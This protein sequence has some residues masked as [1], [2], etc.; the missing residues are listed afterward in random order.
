MKNI[1]LIFFIL[2]SCKLLATATPTPTSAT[3][4]LAQLLKEVKVGKEAARIVAQKREKVF[5]QKRHRQKSLLL[6][7]KKNLKRL[8]ERTQQLTT[9]FESNEK[10]LATLEEKLTITAGT[11][12][13][14][15]GVVKQVAGDFKGQFENSII[16]TQFK[17]RD[18]LMNDLAQRKKLPTISEIS[19]LWYEMTREMIES[20]KIVAFKDDVV[21][22]SGH[23]AQQEIIRIGSFNLIA[24]G[25]YLSYLG[26]T[27]QIIEL[28]RQPQNKYLAMAAD[29]GVLKAGYS[30]F[31]LDPSR[32]AILSMLVQAPSFQ[33]R[34]EQG[35]V[36][37]YVIL[38]LLFIGLILVAE[39][40]VVLFKE[41]QKI[42][43]QLSSEKP[44][45]D[46]ILGQLMKIFNAYKDR[47]SETLELKLEESIIKATPKL[48][49]GISSIKILSAVA[50]LLGLLGT[51]TGMIATFQSI[52]LF[53]TG[54]PKLMA[55]GI[56]TALITTV[57]GLVCAI[58]LL[59]LHN[60]VYTKSK[61]LMQILEEQSA[62][63]M[64]LKVENE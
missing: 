2:F 54:D 38:T 20:G 34:I 21:S 61:R 35:G 16:S 11:L 7:A 4:R 44:L 51:V 56:S 40:F 37:G 26:S 45:D 39:R 13:E 19:R 12:G 22:P 33:E 41:D 15:F 32:G 50:P 49:R 36:V 42:Q 23:K 59:L 57:L 14:M 63:F 43:R 8:N 53:G 29:F 60:V 17:G 5:L 31:G 46:N 27:K 30:A 48:E 24:N 47:D 25:E 58:P 10:E 6:A 52:T 1:Y 55:G 62:G 18:Q 9:T 3:D 64:S 28:P